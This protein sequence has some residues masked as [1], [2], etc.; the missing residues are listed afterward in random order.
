MRLSKTEH[1][2]WREAYW[3]SHC[4]PYTCGI[5]F[6]PAI[7]FLVQ[8]AHG[9]RDRNASAK[10][11]GLQSNLIALFKQPRG[12]PVWIVIPCCFQRGPVKAGTHA[13]IAARYCQLRAWWYLYLAGRRH[14][15]RRARAIPGQCPA[16]Q[17]TQFRYFPRQ[18][19]CDIHHPK[20]WRECRLCDSTCGTNRISAISSYRQQDL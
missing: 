10:R 13:S 9:V 7:D 17:E 8:R 15:D 12:L 19:C 3:P 14:S 11:P 2:R 4:R 16:R 1:L 5:S 18:T 20:F 6:V